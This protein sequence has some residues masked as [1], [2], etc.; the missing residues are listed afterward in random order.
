MRSS[1]S[2]RRDYRIPK[3]FRAIVRDGNDVFS[4]SDREEKLVATALATLMLLEDG[5]DAPAIPPPALDPA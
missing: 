4:V 3:G 1:V 2:I 5:D